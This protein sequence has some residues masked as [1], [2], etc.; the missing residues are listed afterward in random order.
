MRYFCFIGSFILLLNL[1]AQINYSDYFTPERLRYDYVISGNDKNI[2]LVDYM[3]C[4]EPFWGGS[5]VNLFD[6]FAY[7]DMFIEVYDS[8]TNTMIYSRG[9]CT[10]FKEW[11]A[12]DEAHFHNKAYLETV[13]M[14]FP[15]KTILI[16]ILSRDYY[17][18]MYE[19]SR[20][21]LNPCSHDI[22][23]LKQ[24]D[25]TEVQFIDSTGLIAERTDLVFI[26]EGYTKTMRAKFFSDAR[27]FRDVLYKWHPYAELPSAF[28]IY[29]VFAPSE[30]SGTDSP[31]DT[32]WVNTLLESTLNTFGSQH[33]LTVY[34]QHRLH[35][36]VAG[37]P[38]DQIC[39]LVNND[40]YA[41]GGIYNFFA[42][43]TV[44]SEEA[45]FLFHHEFGHAFAGL[46]DEY[47]TSSV[48]YT[49]IFDLQAEPYQPNIT[50]RVQFEKKWIDM[51]PD[52]VPVPTPDTIM[53]AGVVG[54][55]EGASYYAKGV[56]RPSLDCSMRSITHDAFCPVCKKAIEQMIY[57]NGYKREE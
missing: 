44:D 9:Y 39:I 47:Y 2:S 54:L 50:T 7:G 18:N 5:T 20:T 22:K 34:D 30:D 27:R 48:A 42:A 21:Y 16:R 4:K 37:I 38:Y 36:L 33:Y 25:F 17:L 45:E 52:S 28:N 46:A 53:Y 24:P 26:A 32:I 12:T 57:F 11:Q 51:I 6:T 43:F 55:F 41:G 49:D 29:A 19:V 15:H 31:I 8:S 3:F 23:M 40:R 14:P 1:R 13:S 35:D 56:F 10:L